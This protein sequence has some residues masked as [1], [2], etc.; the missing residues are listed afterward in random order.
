M[1]SAVDNMFHNVRNGGAQYIIPEATGGN[2]VEAL[3]TTAGTGIGGN[4]ADVAADAF[5]Q[6]VVADGGSGL[7]ARFSLEG[8]RSLGNVFSYAT[9]KWAL[10]CL[11]VALV[12]NRTSIYASTRRALTLPWQLRVSLRIA[13]ILLLAWQCRQMMQSIHCQTSPEFGML[14]W[15]NAT[16]H[17]DLLH[18]QNGGPLHGI[19]SV[20]LFG[21]S[22]EDAC[23]A[24]KMIPQT[25]DET[26]NRLPGQELEGSLSILWPL[27]QTFSFSQFVETLACALQGRQVAAETGMTLFE[28]SL[29]FAEAD[30]AVSAQLGFGPFGTTKRTNFDGANATEATEIAITRSMLLKR[31]NTTPEVLLVGFLSGMNHLTSHTLAIFN[32]Q[33]RFRLINTATWGL[34]F[35]AIIVYSVFTFTLQD[36]SA[37][38]L[39]RFPTVCIIGFIPHV[40][41]LFGI[42]IC[43]VIYGT[44]LLLSALAPLE[45]TNAE[46]GDDLAAASFM[47]RLKSA[48]QN[49]QANVPLSSIRITMHMDFYTALL[50]TGFSIMTMA[51]EAVYLNES[52]NVTIRPRTWLEDD[53]LKEIESVGAQWLGPSFRIN[54]EDDGLRNGMSDNIG[55]VKTEEPVTGVLK[56]STSPYATEMTA[57]KT[58]VKKANERMVR[59]GVGATER[60]GRWIMALEFF[61][62]IG[63]LLLS[64]WATLVLRM[65]LKVGIVY[66]PRWLVWLIRRPKS[67]KENAAEPFSKEDESTSL[68][69]WMLGKDGE[70]TLPK[71]DGVDVEAEMRRRKQ[72]SLGFWDD[73]QEKELDHSLYDWWRSGGWWG[74][75][76]NSGN[77]SLPEREQDE[78]TTSVMSFSTTDSSSDLDHG[79]ESDS[80]NDDG[81]KT[82]TQRSPHF[83]REGTPFVDNPLSRTDLA[84]LLNP[85][86]PDQRAEA[87]TLAAHLASDQIM[88]RSRY[89]KQSALERSK[90]LLTSSSISRPAHLQSTH[91]PLSPE[92]EAQILEHLILNSR[93][94]KSGIQTSNGTTRREGSGE[95]P[96]CVVCQS[97][98]RTVIVW[99]CRCLSLCDDCRVSLAMNNFDKCVCCRREVGSFSRI[100]VP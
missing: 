85:K 31:V 38:S 89:R 9:S 35:M 1:P 47:D 81:R 40:L 34:S 20:L 8:A 93:A 4:I 22:D 28:H 48:H 2:I 11:L 68:K 19:S 61:L 41:V 14:R 7:S 71:N 56:N 44:A 72:F 18:T 29:A 66:R 92:D 78:D 76:D 32:L 3:T 98:P 79:W 21:Q 49:M 55:L 45:S 94:A 62:G 95:G 77:F 54:D 99:P 84:A 97:S 36:L 60:S 65:F 24:V 59:D 39:L 100:W 15:G 53:R 58:S 80:S 70:L 12:L 96:Q 63:R 17:M 16:K 52:R 10:G 37:Q 69:F 43:A 25:D 13:P 73:D 30:A 90:V 50:R 5:E 87:Q 67:G 27:F 86:T 6:G 64:W 91:S 75:D 88:T 46:G 26:K 51:S 82:P 83:S 74:V 23:L 33:G 42:L 57:K